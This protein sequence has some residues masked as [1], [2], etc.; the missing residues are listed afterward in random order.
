[1]KSLLDLIWNDEIED[2]ELDDM[3]NAF[4]TNTCIAP[5]CGG[6]GPVTGGHLVMANPY[7]CP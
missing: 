6:T 7:Y 2:D 5:N 4:M 3:V 1:M